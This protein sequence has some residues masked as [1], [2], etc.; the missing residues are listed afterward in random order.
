MNKALENT[1]KIKVMPILISSFKHKVGTKQQLVCFMSKIV[2]YVAH[3]SLFT[4]E[5]LLWSRKNN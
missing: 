1:F 4:Q 2:L 5:T 3:S